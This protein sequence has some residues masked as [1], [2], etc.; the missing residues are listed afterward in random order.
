M[1][2]LPSAPDALEKLAQLSPA[3]PP[4]VG[5]TDPSELINLPS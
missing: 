3:L 2:S 5:G 4:I 1:T